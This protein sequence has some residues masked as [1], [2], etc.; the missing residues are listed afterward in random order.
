MNNKYIANIPDKE[1]SRIAPGRC[2][3]KADPKTEDLNMKQKFTITLAGMDIN[4]IS[5]ESPESVENI[6]GIIDRRIREINL[7]SPRCSRTEAALLCALDYCA[8]KVALT[9][10][11][12]ELEDAATE[13]SA[14]NEQKS[15]DENSRN[16]EISQKLQN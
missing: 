13:Q 16:D 14:L 6:V 3:R 10:R 1:K 2:R 12:K 4:V 11:I 5:E 9:E 8:E 15:D 7:K